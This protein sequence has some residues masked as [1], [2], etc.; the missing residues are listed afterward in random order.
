MAIKLQIRRDTLTNWSA[1]SS[2]VLL[3][4]EIGYVTDTRNMKIGDGTTIWSSLK[5]QAPYYTGTNSSLAITTLSVDQT[6]NRVGIG[7]SSPAS[8]LDV[9]GQ[10]RVRGTTAYSAPADNVAA[11]N[12]D[13]TSGVMTVDA[14]SNAGSTVIAVH[15]SNATAGAERLRISSAGNVGIGATNPSNLVHLKGASPVIRLED[16]DGADSNLYCLIDADNVNGTLKLGANNGNVVAQQNNAFVGI[17]VNGTERFRANSSGVQI[18]GTTSVSGLITANGGLT[19]PTGDTL[20]VDTGGTIA[21][22]TGANRILSGASI[23]DN[24]IALSS[25]ANMAAAGVLGATAAGAVTALTSGIGGT[26]KTALGLGTAAYSNGPSTISPAAWNDLAIA[27]A[28]N[29]DFSASSLSIGALTLVNLA[30]SRT[31]ATN[32]VVNAR[33]VLAAGEIVTILNASDNNSAGT[34]W[35]TLA[36]NAYATWMYRGSAA[37]TT[38][39]VDE[40]NRDYPRPITLAG[41]QTYSVLRW[42]MGGTAGTAGPRCWV[43]MLR[44]A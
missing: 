21:F 12:Y 14:R 15:T 9:T 1:N 17:T 39:T 35:S 22:P 37:G 41:A 38:S 27:S 6:N 7:N 23:T 25:I 4:G 24:S 31:G 30:F 34:D 19:I 44:Q 26:A 43:L 32:A 11:I 18:T 8:T 36:S 33:L 3:E 16:T 28:A 2:V 42:Q 40:Y 29:K 5:Y 13:S 20:T 10:V